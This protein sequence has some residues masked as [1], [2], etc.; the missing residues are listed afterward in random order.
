MTKY[1]EKQ[2]ADAVMAYETGR[3]GLLATAEAQGV[4]F[5]SLRVWVAQFRARGLAGVSRKK[6]S[7]YDF[8]FKMT[9]LR[10]MNDDGLSSRQASA[11]FDIRRLDQVAE[12]SRLY[13]NH[14]PEALRPGWKKIQSE[15]NKRPIGRV[16]AAMPGDD[17]RSREDLLRDLKQLRMEN[18]Y[19]KKA[20]ALVRA[21]STSA[22][23]RER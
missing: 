12:W 22:L 3:A 5:D 14:G 23:K 17:Q 21:R 13:A 1:T 19:L 18:A 7:S 8:E 4:S 10:R 6:R 20:H 9:V 16:D 11:L 15:M 2:K